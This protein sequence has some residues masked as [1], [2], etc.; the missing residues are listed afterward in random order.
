MR[1]MHRFSCWIWV[2]LEKIINNAFIAGEARMQFCKA[3]FW[4]L[5]LVH[6]SKLLL[7]RMHILSSSF[8][9]K[10]LSNFFWGKK[11]AIKSITTGFQT[12]FRIIYLKICFFLHVLRKLIA[13]W[14]GNI[15]SDVYMFT[16]TSQSLD[17]LFADVAKD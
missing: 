8:T 9:W 13:L 1:G 16:N 6:G 14:K 7:H 12:D 3:V 5:T 2:D 11:K 10:R 17:F 4:T 15:Y